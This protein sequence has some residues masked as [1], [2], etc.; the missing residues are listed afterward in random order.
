MIKPQNYAVFAEYESASSEVGTVHS[1][2]T[3]D[4]LEQAREMAMEIMKGHG[5]VFIVLEK[6]ELINDNYDD[7][8]EYLYNPL[9]IYYS[10]WRGE[11]TQLIDIDGIEVIQTFRILPNGEE[12]P[13]G[14]PFIYKD[15]E[16][17]EPLDLWDLFIAVKF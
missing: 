14:E 15:D 11:E 7:V 5:G 16:Y 4:T 10:E 2:F 8:I 17:E 6:N 1:L 13:E 9:A 3:F 12:I